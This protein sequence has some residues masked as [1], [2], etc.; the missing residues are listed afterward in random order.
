MQIKKWILKKMKEKGQT[1]QLSKG[2]SKHNL[3]SAQPDRRVASH[4]GR[5]GTTPV[6]H[7]TVTVT[8]SSP[9]SPVLEVYVMVMECLLIGWHTR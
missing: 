9:L 1:M 3:R 4:V 2:E 8:A 7:T 6:T 5:A